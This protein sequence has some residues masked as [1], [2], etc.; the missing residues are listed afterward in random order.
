MANKVISPLLMFKKSVVG[1]TLN[2]AFNNKYFD[3]RDVFVVD[4]F[5]LHDRKKSVYFRKV[6]QL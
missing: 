2:L 5:T 1:K 3:A 6:I 4:A